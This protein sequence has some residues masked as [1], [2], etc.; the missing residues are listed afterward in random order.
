MTY[1][2]LSNS[3]ISKAAL[4]R[5]VTKA[6]SYIKQILHRQSKQ[7]ACNFLTRLFCRQ[8][9]IW[10]KIVS[11]FGFLNYFFT[12]D[13]IEG[14]VTEKHYNAIAMAVPFIAADIN[15]GTCFYDQASLITF[16]T[17]YSDLLCCCVSG[18]M[19]AS[20]F[21]NIYEETTNYFAVR[22]NF[23]KC[24]FWYLNRGNL[25]TLQTHE[26]NH[27]SKNVKLFRHTCFLGTSPLSIST[28][29]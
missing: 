17:A 4:P 1:L 28:I 7:S 19:R 12:Y 6:R 20:D 23:A 18:E 15:K 10:F 21:F 11:K 26:L 8:P 24:S 3:D 16:H 25:F 13:G 2:A 5:Q 27:F 22:E 14:S 9:A 29:T